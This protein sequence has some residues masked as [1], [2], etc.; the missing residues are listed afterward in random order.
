MTCQQKVRRTGRCVAAI[1]AGGRSRRMGGRDKAVLRLGGERLIDRAIARLQRQAEHVVLS[2]PHD[3]GTGLISIADAPEAPKGPAA[4]VYSVCKWMMANEPSVTGFVTAPVDSPFAPGDLVERLAGGDGAAIA[5]DGENDQPAL[6]Y[7][8]LDILSA[9]WPD[10]EGQSSVSLRALADIC[11]ARRVVWTDTDVFLN[12]NSPE[13][14]E[15]A[16]AVDSV[17][18]AG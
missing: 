15:A 3:Y 14:L 1:L 16:R 6:G 4:G 12:I 10:L 18:Q 9:V 11:A 2:A 5:S 8:P 13:D 7:W 17:K